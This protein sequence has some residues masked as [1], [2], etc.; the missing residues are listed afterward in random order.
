MNSVH[1]E[2]NMGNASAV[3][4]LEIYDTKILLTG[5]ITYTV[6]QKIC[7]SYDMC[8]SANE[9]YCPVNGKSVMLDSCDIFTVPAHGSLDGRYAQFYKLLNAQTAIISVGENNRSCPSIEVLSDVGKVTDKI[10]VTEYYGT[11]PFVITS[12]GYSL[13]E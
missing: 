7:N 6:A 8:L 11:V 4:W 12:T 13:I 2:K 9:K 1:G 10:Y 3:I 5:D